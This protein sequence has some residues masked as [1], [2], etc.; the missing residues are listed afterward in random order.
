M[1]LGMLKFK[2]REMKTE[3]QIEADVIEADFWKYMEKTEIE[4]GMRYY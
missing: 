4:N 2:N 3:E 1:R